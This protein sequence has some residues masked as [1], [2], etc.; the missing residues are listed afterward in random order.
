MTTKVSGPPHRRSITSAIP[1][2]PSR[3]RGTSANSPSTVLSHLFERMLRSV[4]RI[5]FSTWAVVLQRSAAAW[6]IGIVPSGVSKAWA[7]G[8]AR[9]AHGTR[10]T[11]PRRTTRARGRVRLRARRRAR[12]DR[13]N[14]RSPRAGRPAPSA[15]RPAASPARRA[16]AALAPRRKRARLA[17]VEHAGD[18]RRSDGRHGDY[19]LERLQD[20]FQREDYGLPADAFA[21]AGEAPA[22]PTRRCAQAIHTVPTGFSGCRRPGPRCR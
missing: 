22:S 6:S 9:A 3:P 7:L 18:G 19:L 1:P 11:G 15:S 12:R 10:W 16:R 20:P 13:P 2:S 14:R 21:V 5:A 8:A 4:R 17:R